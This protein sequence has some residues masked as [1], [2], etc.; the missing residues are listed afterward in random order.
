MPKSTT[1][2]PFARI[3]AAAGEVHRSPDYRFENA[4]RESP[5]SL[6]VQRTTRGAGFL[7]CDTG[8]HLVG[9][10]QAMLFSHSEPSVYG[11]P[12]E[13]QEPYEFQFICFFPGSLRLLFERL[14]S[15]HGS[16]LQMP[17]KSESATLFGEIMRCYREHRFRDQLEECDL[18]H[19]LLLALYRDQIE[20]SEDP[21]QLGLHAIR[22]H[23]RANVNLKTIAQDCG[24]SRE[25]FIRQFTLRYGESPGSMLRR[26]RL[27]HARAMLLSTRLSVQEV[28]LASGFSSSNAFCRA[29]RNA[30]AS[31]PSETR[32]E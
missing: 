20:K 25:H 11:F 10:G 22:S 21:I 27:E 13:A 19:R 4:H 9:A 23:F 31:S 3:R 8:R 7:E 26:F 24:V 15:E 32:S 17:E 2:N 5:E 29:Y 28:A 14:R 16:V 18:L 6:V 30:Y 1:A 12:P